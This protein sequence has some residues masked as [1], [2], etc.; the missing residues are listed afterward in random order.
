[1]DARADAKAGKEVD[2][3]DVEKLFFLRC[4]CLNLAVFLLVSIVV[5]ASIADNNQKAINRA[6][7]QGKLN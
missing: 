6:T 4:I 7:D 2:T 3:C 5:M 1:M